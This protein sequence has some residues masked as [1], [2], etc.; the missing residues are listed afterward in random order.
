MPA[1]RQDIHYFQCQ[2]SP[3]PL[4]CTL[5]PKCSQPLLSLNHTFPAP[6]C[7]CLYLLIPA[8]KCPF[9]PFLMET[10]LISP[11]VYLK[12]YLSHKNLLSFFRQVCQLW[13]YWHSETD[14]SRHRVDVALLCIIGSSWSSLTRCTLSPKCDCRRCFQILPMSPVREHKSLL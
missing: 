10:L 4:L 5:Y 8:L 12:A 2:C 11:K 9:S 3:G 14:K 7:S 6:A 1:S 13:Y